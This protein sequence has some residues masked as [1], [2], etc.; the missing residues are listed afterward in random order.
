MVIRIHV[1]KTKLL[2]VGL[3]LIVMLFIGLVEAL[4]Y[5]SMKIESHVGVVSLKIQYKCGET[6]ST[7]QNIKPFI[8]VFNTGIANVSLTSI[9][10]RY[11]FTSEPL[12]EDV[13]S[14]EYAEVGASTV[15][16]SFGSSGNKYYLEIGFTSN[17]TV[18]L[19]RGGDGTPNKLPAEANTGEIQIKIYNEDLY[20]Q[21]DDY[22]FDPTKT[23]YADW[24][25][26]TIY[27]QGALAWGT[28][29]A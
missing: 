4:I 21:T 16:G 29:P 26:I 6:S 1:N 9:K 18:P 3:F 12:G 5:N 22:S 13:F 15:I 14:C 11:W 28:E 8:I 25:K 20:N 17:A 19:E 23:D 10:I 7:T 27:Y 2:W 24:Y